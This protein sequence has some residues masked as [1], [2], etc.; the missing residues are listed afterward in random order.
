MYYDSL[1]LAGALISFL[2]FLTIPWKYDKHVGID[3]Y[4]IID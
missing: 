2:N 3:E 4:F 1:L